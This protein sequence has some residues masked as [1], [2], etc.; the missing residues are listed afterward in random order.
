MVTGG[1]PLYSLGCRLGGVGL[2]MFRN[3]A[4]IRARR[5]GPGTGFHDSTRSQMEG[6]VGETQRSGLGGIQLFTRL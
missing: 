1:N 3:L 2:L 4:R 5:P 6:W